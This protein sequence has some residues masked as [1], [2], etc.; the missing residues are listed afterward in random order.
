M[1]CVTYSSSDT[2]YYSTIPSIPPLISSSTINNILKSVKRFN[3]TLAFFKAAYYA[4]SGAVK[5]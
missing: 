5:N 4:Y 1:K 3:I 2:V